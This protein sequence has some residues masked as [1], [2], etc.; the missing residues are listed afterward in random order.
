[1]IEIHTDGSFIP[2]GSFGSWGFVA[3]QDGIQIH[4]SSGRG[5]NGEIPSSRAAEAIAIEKALQW[6][7][8]Q[9]L[10]SQPVLLKT[11][12]KDTVRLIVG[13]KTTQSKTLAP[14]IERIQDMVSLIQDLRIKETWR[15]QILDAHILARMELVFY[16]KMKRERE[17]AEKRVRPAD[18]TLVVETFAS[19]IG[20][21]VQMAAWAYLVRHGSTP[22]TS[23][24]RIADVGVIRKQG[25]RLILESIAEALIELKVMAL[26]DRPIWICTTSRKAVELVADRW[27]HKNEMEEES[28]KRVRELGSV[29]TALKLIPVDRK[30]VKAAAELARRRLQPY[31]EQYN[32]YQRRHRRLPGFGGSACA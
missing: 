18:N 30:G 26:S 8:Q 6:V 1:M 27:P 25:D 2:D 29:F 31:R 13:A 21:P 3:L 24:V 15:D 12:S 28:A 20:Y 11:D 23:Q 16:R 19:L 5:V 22:Y 17:R 4:E 14:I 10:H 32:E 9:G 7:I